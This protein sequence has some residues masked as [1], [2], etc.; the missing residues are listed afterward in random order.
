MPLYNRSL[1]LR[2]F[3]LESSF[4]SFALPDNRV[5]ENVVIGDETEQN[6]H[7]SAQRAVE[8]PGYVH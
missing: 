4:Y 3:E 8:R 7:S 6:E 5:R 2:R 1:I